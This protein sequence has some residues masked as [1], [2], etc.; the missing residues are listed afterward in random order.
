MGTQHVAY[1]FLETGRASVKRADIAWRY[2]FFK[3]RRDFV[4]E[5]L[6]S[7][8]RGSDFTVDRYQTFFRE[9]AGSLPGTSTHD[10][11]KR[12]IVFSSL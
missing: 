10:G 2:F 12:Q 8:A 6:T 3:M 11:A 4:D 7:K 1:Q 5:H 9:A